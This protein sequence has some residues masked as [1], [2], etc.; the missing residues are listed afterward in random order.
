M[1]KEI[2]TKVRLTE[3]QFVH[4]FNLMV[5]S[6]VNSE[7]NLTYPEYLYKKDSYY[8]KYKT[9]AERISHG[10]LKVIRIR[11][12]EKL[13]DESARNILFGIKKWQNY[14]SL[15]DFRNSICTEEKLSQK[16]MYD[17]EVT[18]T[19]K[20]KVLENGVEFNEETESVINNEKALE[21]FFENADYIRWFNKEKLSFSTYINFVSNPELVF[22]SE[23]ETVNGM[24]YIEIEYT[25]DE[26]SPDVVRKNLEK[27]ISSLGANLSNKDSRSWVEI[28]EGSY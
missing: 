7:I 6:E 21:V 23:L 15:M 22:H 9:R 3:E 11:K 24:P 18:F 1:A 13:I 8:S 25:K 10:E 26:P 19:V 16:N 20:H 2:E 14:S 5:G 4:I 17:Q 12:E 28:V 27:L